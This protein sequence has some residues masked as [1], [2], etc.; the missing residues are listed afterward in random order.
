MPPQYL[1]EPHELAINTR[2]INKPAIL[3]VDIVKVRIHSDRF[4]RCV[5]GG[6]P[7]NVQIQSWGGAEGL[8]AMQSRAMWSPNGYAVGSY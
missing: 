2:R 4:R 8:V 7:F 1:I 5:V 3:K 6:P